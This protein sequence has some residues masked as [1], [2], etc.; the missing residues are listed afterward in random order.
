MKGKAF[1]KYVLRTPLLSMDTISNINI[2]K[3]KDLISKPI[4]REAIYIA[5]HEL[6]IETEKYLNNEIND[7]KRKKKLEHALLRYL[8]RMSYRCTPFGLFAGC[9][10]GKFTNETKVSLN[11]INKYSR[12]TRLDMHY[13]CNLS[14]DLSK[15]NN[16]REFFKYYPNTSLYSVADQLRYVE[17]KNKNNSKNHF[18]SS[19]SNSVYL[20]KVLEKA[21]KGAY[22][23]DLADA[24]IDDEIKYEDAKGFIY[25]L[26]ENQILVS[27]IEH[28]VTGDEYLATINNGINHQSE[29]FNILKAIDFKLNEIDKTS[30]GESL[31]L[32]EDVIND[33]NKLKTPF[34]KGILFQSDL[35]TSC[36]VNTINT[37]VINDVWEG[38]S[39]LNK[40]TWYSKNSNLE[41]FKELFYKRYEDEEVPLAQ[42]LDTDFGIGYGESSYVGYGDITPLVD[43]LNLPQRTNSSMPWNPV[44]DLLS[45][46]YAKAIANCEDEINLTVEDLNKLPNKNLNLAPTFSAFFEVIEQDSNK[47]SVRLHY[48][49]GSSAACLIGRFCHSDR[50]VKNYVEEIIDIEE[51]THQGKVFAEIAHLPQKRAGNVLQRPHLRKFE[52][53]F[54]ANSS[55]N[56][57][58][59]IPIDDLLVSIRNEKVILRSRKLN[60]EII[61]R[62]TTAH[63]YTQ[64]SLP[65]YSFLC[66]IQTQYY[67]DRICFDWGHYGTSKPFLPRVTYKNLILSPETWNFEKNTLKSTISKITF[68]EDIVQNCKKWRDEFNIPERILIVEFDFQMF[69]DLSNELFVQLFIDTIKK[70]SKIQIQEFLYKSNNNLVKKGTESYTNQIICSFQNQSN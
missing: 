65:I 53:P 62:L 1:D 13:L 15:D 20:S 19:V 28:S 26:I 30:L 23:K 60:K 69:L 6:H 18:I 56:D 63:N 5:S 51:S 21:S 9:S 10:L 45:N 38:I 3:L 47:Y 8:I 35:I 61:P 52:I 70:K 16:N 31:E 48:A 32:Y 42:V 25:E 14:N 54:L 67:D 37:S 29:S 46:K 34:D 50:N 41:R 22:I 43:D 27:N 66:D 12:H 49:G 17:Y 58:F 39:V 55:L 24:L 4:I 36:N 57:E 11:S 59:K 33:L 68:T 44:L 2:N 64:G 7:P 40:L